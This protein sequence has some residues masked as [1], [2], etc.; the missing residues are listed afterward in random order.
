[1]RVYS[2]YY[3]HDQFS[4]DM[5]WEMF[6]IV[7]ANIS[8]CSSNEFTEKS[9]NLSNGFLPGGLLPEEPVNINGIPEKYRDAIVPP[10]YWNWSDLRGTNWITSVKHQG[11]CGSCAAFAA[12]G[13]VEAMMTLWALDPNLDMDLSEQHLFCCAGGECA[14]GL[15]MGDAFDYFTNSGV[16][17]EECWAMFRYMS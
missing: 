1:M 5:V 17:D 12:C 11:G 7:I 3:W 15:Y 8:L 2:L 4:F 13:A 16:P 10:A 6:F 9:T 14:S